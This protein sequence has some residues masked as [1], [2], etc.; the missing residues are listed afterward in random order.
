MQTW[1]HCTLSVER[2]VVVLVVVR[3]AAFALSLRR[4]YAVL[5]S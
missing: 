3:G 1:I 4:L 5:S 2:C